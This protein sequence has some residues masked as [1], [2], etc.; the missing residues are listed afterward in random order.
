MSNWTRVILTIPAEH[1]D[2][3][4]KLAS[5]FDPDTGG[6]STFGA[7]ALS[8]TGEAPATH[9]MANTQIKTEYLPV[10]SDPEQALSALTALAEEYDREPPTEADVQAWC[11][12]AIIGTE[13]PEGLL[14]IVQE[15]LGP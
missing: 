10:L 8:P 2:A 11:D 3:A 7:C 1:V 9:Y 15:D 13:Q 14:R 6:A 4:N 12:N 5:I